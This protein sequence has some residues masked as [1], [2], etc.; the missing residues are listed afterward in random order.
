MYRIKK[1]IDMRKVNKLV[2]RFYGEMVAATVDKLLL[3]HITPQNR[4]KP[5][6]TI[7]EINYIL[8]RYGMAAVVD[9]D[10]LNIIAS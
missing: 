4:M 3:G 5:E 2:A 6:C 1:A 10:K 7:S 8:K 9:G